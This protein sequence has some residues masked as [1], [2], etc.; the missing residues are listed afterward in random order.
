MIAIPPWT[1]RWSL[2]SLVGGS[3]A[4]ERVRLDVRSTSP[5]RGRVTDSVGSCRRPRRGDCRGTN[6]GVV[7]AILYDGSAEVQ[8]V[9][10]SRDRPDRGSAERR[11]TRVVVGT[12]ALEERTGLRT[13]LRTTGTDHPRRRRARSPTRHYG[14]AQ[15]LPQTS[16]ISSMSWTACRLGAP[17]HSRHREGQ[18][19]GVDLP[20]MEDGP[21]QRMFRFRVRRRCLGAELRAL[22]DRGIAGVVI[23]MALYTGALDRGRSQRSLQNETSA[24]IAALE[25]FSHEHDRSRDERDPDPCRGPRG[26][27]VGDI[28]TSVRFLDHM[29]VT[30]ARYSGLDLS[31]RARGD[32]K[33]HIIEDVA[34]CVGAALADLV[35]P[36]AGRYGIARCDGDA[37]VQ[38]ALDV[39]GRPTTRVRFRARSTIIGC[40]RSRQR[41]DDVASA[42]AAWDRPSSRCRSCVQGTRLRAQRRSHRPRRQRRCLQHK[43]A[44]VLRDSRRVAGQQ[45]LSS[46]TARCPHN[47]DPASHR[48]PRVKAVASSRE[49][50]LSHFA[51]LAIPRTWRSATSAKC[52][53]F[54]SLTSRRAPRSA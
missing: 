10:A 6:A 37:L 44:V 43:G 15:H 23:G 30:L 42:C 8:V 53:R 21:K 19:Q 5:A 25:E 7:R 26:S 49:L 46:L 16:W 27:G 11:A 3:Y 47:A 32:L 13:L 39:G 28:D 51:M 33:H 40:V 41:A 4:R 50:S 14:W 36:G 1:A 2:R 48:L 31:V 20:L 24:R 45:R 9:V 35:P 17:R 18:M 54:A 12:R 22:A 29:L 34:I 52:G 38:C